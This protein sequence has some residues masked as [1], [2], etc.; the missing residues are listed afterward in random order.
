MGSEHNYQVYVVGDDG[1]FFGRTDIVCT[2]D[3]AAEARTKQMVD[4]H[5]CEL[6]D[7][8]RKIA[9]FEPER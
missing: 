6:W 8:A 4:G 9:V 1:H 3:D 2:S 7:G 5:A